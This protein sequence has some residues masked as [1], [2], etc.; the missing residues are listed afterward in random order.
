L[1]DDLDLPGALACVREM[2]RADLTPDERRWLVLDADAV[3]GLDLHRVW[4]APSTEAA[5]LDVPTDV[6]TLLADRDEAR[7]ARDFARADDLRRELAN[8]GWDVVDGPGGSTVRR[9]PP[10]DADE[11]R[12][13]S[14]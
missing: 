14:E 1:D 10:P 5:A 3:L 7:S 13:Q 2:L 9:A 6:T 11:P 8:L 12:L 4:E